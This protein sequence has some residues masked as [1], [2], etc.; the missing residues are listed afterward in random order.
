MLFFIKIN[1]KPVGSGNDIDK[2]VDLIF[3]ISG[4]L[5]FSLHIGTTP[6]IFTSLLFTNSVMSNSNLGFIEHWT[7]T[8]Q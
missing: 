8:T 3:Y 2:E 7:R 6:F 5:K 4:Y 1:L